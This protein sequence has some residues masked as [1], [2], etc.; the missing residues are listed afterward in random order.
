MMIC[1][2]D[3]LDILL[4]CDGENGDDEEDLEWVLNVR[5]S[6]DTS[7]EYLEIT[8]PAVRGKYSRTTMNTQARK[9]GQVL[10][11]NLS[12]I[13]RKYSTAEKFAFFASC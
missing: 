3:I 6:D 1:R 8:L 13:S 4:G 11:Q 2:S 9:H 5:V 7:N 12:P 10:V